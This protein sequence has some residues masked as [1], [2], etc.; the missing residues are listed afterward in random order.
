MLL[1]TSIFSFECYSIF[2]LLHSRDSLS[3]FL[4]YC[5]TL[6]FPFT[7]SYEYKLHDQTRILYFSWRCSSIVIFSLFIH[8]NGSFINS[9]IKF[10]LK[11]A[12][13]PSSGI[14][15]S[16]ATCL[17]LLS[18]FLIYWRYVHL[19]Q[20]L[21]WI[22]ICSMNINISNIFL[23]RTLTSFSGTC[24]FHSSICLKLVEFS[25]LITFSRQV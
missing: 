2:L 1:L 24:F 17:L 11:S 21:A 15:K 16:L 14:L 13:L 3:F 4:C 5:F 12:S 19:H 9:Q 8:G 7:S 10:S 6:T 18:R 25:L 22:F 23:F 20:M